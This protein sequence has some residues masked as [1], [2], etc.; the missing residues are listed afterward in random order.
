MRKKLGLCL[1]LLALM[2]VL[3]LSAALA[4]CSLIFGPDA[5]I[6][7][8]RVEVDSL[9]VAQSPVVGDTLRI[10]FYGF[11]G[12]NGQYSF[13]YFEASREPYRLDITVWGK[14]VDDGGPH[15]D[16]EVHLRGRE[17]A[18]ASLHAG[19]LLIVVHQPDG[20]TL[21]YVVNV[22]AADVSVTSA[23]PN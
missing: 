8:F 19:D 2:G 12:P 15:H 20:V 14:R 17:Y 22:A 10:A 23:T 1:V 3:A 6:E 4:S 11:I 9:R 5:H 16:A 13:A 7:L 21:E 18:L